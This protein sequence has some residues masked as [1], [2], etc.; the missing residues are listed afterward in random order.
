MS[1]KGKPPCKLYLLRYVGLVVGI[2]RA[3]LFICLVW[4]PITKFVLSVDFPQPVRD[5]YLIAFVQNGSSALLRALR[6]GRGA[7]LDSTGGS[8]GGKEQPP[9]MGPRD[10]DGLDKLLRTVH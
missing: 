5:S 4:M 7:D 9:G 3:A 10:R 8:L 1:A 6:R 2:A